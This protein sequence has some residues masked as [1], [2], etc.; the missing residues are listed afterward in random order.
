MCLTLYYMNDV[1]ICGIKKKTDKRSSKNNQINNT[2]RQRWD[3]KK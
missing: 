1:C 2:E 3:K